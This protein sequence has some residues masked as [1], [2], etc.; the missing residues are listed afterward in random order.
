ML[1]FVTNDQIV[2]QF[3]R[4]IMQWSFAEALIEDLLAGM[5]GAELKYVW[6]LTANINIS[7]RIE[8][9]RAV[10]RMRLSASAFIEFES[11]LDQF[12]MLV[13]FRNKLVHGLWTDSDDPSL[14]EVYVIKSSGKIKHQ[15]EYVNLDYLNLDYLN[16][17]TRQIEQTFT[18]LFG[19]GRRNGLLKVQKRA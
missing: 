13:P 15:S 10:G 8:A 16:W 14:A 11:A 6:A 4:I 17:L 2:L 18:L 19:F 1:P 5:M 7:T 9:L 3:G 12:R